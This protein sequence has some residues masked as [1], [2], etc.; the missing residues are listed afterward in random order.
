MYDLAKFTLTDMTRCGSTLR[1]LGTGA[2]SME[3]AAGRVVRHLRDN[4]VCGDTGH[5]ACALVRFFK[6]HRYGELDADLKLFADQILGDSPRSDDMKCLTL[7]ASSGD[8]PEWN[9]RHDSVGHKA[10][11]LPSQQA[12]HRIPMISQLIKQLGLEIGALVETPASLLV[13]DEQRSYNVF[14]VPDARRSPDIPAQE[15]F[16]DRFGIR[17]VLGFGGLLPLGDLFT[18]I[19]F[20]TESIPRETTELFKPLAL[21]TKMAVLPFVGNAVFAARP[22]DALVSADG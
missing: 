10:I 3:E 5:R 22:A 21:C 20:S 16:V 13:D 4:L 18:V 7:L 14:Y 19:L 9:H 2:A 11:P 17:S 6:T 8:R 12:V 15:E 1:K